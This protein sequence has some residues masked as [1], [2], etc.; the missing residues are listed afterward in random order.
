MLMTHRVGA[1]LVL[2]GVVIALSP[3]FA[4]STG[5]EEISFKATSA[6]V[7]ETGVP[8]RIRLTRWSTDAERAPLVAA[9]T[10]AARAAAPPAPPEAAAD[11][12]AAPT[13]RGAGAGAGA[14]PAAG[15]GAAGRGGAGRGAAR[16]GAPGRGGRGGAPAAPVTPIVALMAAI[17]KAPTLGYIWT[18]EVTGYAIKYAYRAPLAAGGERIVL[19]TDRRLGGYTPG[20]QPVAKTPLTDYEFTVVEMELDARGAGDAKTSLTSKVIVDAEAKTLALDDYAAAPVILQNVK[21]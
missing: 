5:T 18:N 20:W 4:Q 10:P 13:G 11:D 1:V 21:R 7:R 16:S 2:F 9:L 8:V 15:R 14:A 6:N 12:G 3:A 17:A 19:A